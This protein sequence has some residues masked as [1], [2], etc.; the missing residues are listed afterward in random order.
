M[1]LVMLSTTLSLWNGIHGILDSRFPRDYVVTLV[2]NDLDTSKQRLLDF[3]NDIKMENKICYRTISIAALLEGDT[4]DFDQSKSN[5]WDYSSLA[6]FNFF[7]LEDFNEYTGLD[8]NLESGEVFLYSEEEY[9]HNQ[10]IVGD[11]TY[12]I[13][14]KLDAFFPNNET[15]MSVVSSYSLVVRDVNE[16][17]YIYDL[18]QEVYD[19]YSLPNT[20]L[21]FDSKDTSYDPDKMIQMYYDSMDNSESDSYTSISVRSKEQENTELVGLYSGFLFLG[22]FLSI[23][24]IL[25][26]VSIMYYKQINEGYQDKDRFSIMSKVG[27]DSSDI[28]RSINSQILTVFFLPLIVSGIHMCFAFRLI[29][30]LLNLL[31]FTDI[32]LFLLTSII[33][34][35]VFAILYAIVYKLTSKAYYRIVKS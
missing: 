7:L 4:L 1:V 9:D 3:E 2:N 5:M 13:K 33:C 31:Y 21:M 20:T 23:L 26:M 34:F 29:C 6:S 15:Q 22:I 32:S 18:N 28:K 10:I 11:K 19:M 12:H 30:K 24:F 17:Q 25:A 16:L 14:D 35:V 8:L 27:L